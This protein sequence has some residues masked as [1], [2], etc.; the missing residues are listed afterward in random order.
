MTERMAEKRKWYEKYLPFVAQSRRMQV[1]WL[2]GVIRKNVLHL[3]EVTPYIRLLLAEE[4]VDESESLV[5]LLKDL[6]EDVICRMV[7]AA[8]IYD[9]AR[10]MRLAP[11]PTV[12]QAVAALVK[13]PPPYEKK[14][15]LV[16]DKIF[17]AIHDRSESLF[18]EAASELRKRDDAPPHFESAYGRFQEIL[19]DERI[20]SAMYPKARA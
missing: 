11:A 15:E 20:L 2:V 7:M 12:E 1:E 4:E 9:V 17:Q 6:D 16:L 5:A 13:E 14:P 10:L 8:D 3:E 18:E 19:A